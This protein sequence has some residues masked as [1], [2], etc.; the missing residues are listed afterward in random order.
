MLLDKRQVSISGNSG[1]VG[2]RTEGRGQ[3]GD[4]DRYLTI[5]GKKAYHIGNKC[6]TCAFLFE[7]LHGA[8]RSVNVDELT[9]QLNSGLKRLESSAVDSLQTIMPGGEYHVLLLQGWP[10]LVYPG[11]ES[12]YFSGEQVD[13]WGVDK[14]WGMPHSPRTEYYRLQT[15]VLPGQRGLF[16]FLIPMFPHSWLNQER[17]ARYR[18]LVGKEETSTAVTVSVLDVKAPADCEA[19]TTVSTHWCL[20]HYLID[21]HHKTYAAAEAGKPLTFISFL[22][23]EHSMSSEDELNELLTIL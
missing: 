15:T 11:N 21:G 2:F 3:W 9:A 22:A 13:L 8:N 18:E 12:D 7:R 10:R 6:G 17:V 14:F 1:I 4:W 5:E 16:E 20:A 23:T 19:E